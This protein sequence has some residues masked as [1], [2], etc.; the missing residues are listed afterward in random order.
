MDYDSYA[1]LQKRYP[2]TICNDYMMPADLRKRFD[3]GIMEVAADDRA[4]FLFESR[5][6]F[7]K[8]H[9]R[10]MDTSAKLKSREGTIA[11]YLTYR[12]GNSPEDAAG[13]LLEQG[14][15]KIKSL[16]R[17]TATNIVGDLTTDGVDRASADEAYFMLGE[18]FGAAEAD[19]PCRELFEGALCIRSEER[20]PVGTIY[21]GRPSILAVAPEARGDGVGRRL[22]RAYAA[23]KIS[24]DNKSLFHEWVSPDNAESLA[25]FK[26][27]GFAADDVFTD[28][29]VRS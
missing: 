12:E 17:H 5:E 13:W 19:L 8:L 22:Y 15:K 16:R 2:R 18:Y 26:S 24:E 10:L 9:F 1:D 3:S 14:F 28:C 25:M 27:L 21:L 29:Y 4:L 6:G 20:V 11:A 23:I 7:T